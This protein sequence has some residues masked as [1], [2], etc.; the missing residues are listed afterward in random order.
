MVSETPSYIGLTKAL[1]TLLDRTFTKPYFPAHISTQTPRLLSL[2]GGP[3]HGCSIGP[4]YT[5]VSLNR[6]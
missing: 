3:P 6:T 5:P 4:H 1:T 2:L